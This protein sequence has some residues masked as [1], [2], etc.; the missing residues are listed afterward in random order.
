M[1]GN[2]ESEPSPT[3]FVFPETDIEAPATPANLRWEEWPGTGDDKT[4]GMTLRLMWDSSPGATSYSIVKNDVLV[5]S[6]VTSTSWTDTDVEYLGRYA[7]DVYAFSSPRIRTPY[8]AYE[9]GTLITPSFGTAHPLPDDLT[10]MHS[11]GD[12]YRLSWTPPEDARIRAWMTY[13]V[14][15][16]PEPLTDLEGSVPISSSHFFDR[17]ENPAYEKYYYML[18][19]RLGPYVTYAQPSQVIRFDMDPI[20]I[21]PA[22]IGAFL[23]DL[24]EP[25]ATSDHRGSLDDRVTSRAYRFTLTQAKTVTLKV[26][27]IRYSDSDLLLLDDELNELETSQ[28]KNK[29][30]E[31]IT[32]ALDPGTYYA[33]VDNTTAD[34]TNNYLFTIEVSP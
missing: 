10:L 24:G 13:N 29:A 31:T 23:V 14:R 12:L 6:R 26:T 17:L 32:R 33:Y 16:F 30:D 34:G 22:D 2:T 1:S 11:G 5:A 25:P 8:S 27:N 21:G 3:I 9:V 28:N 18:R 15:R 19:I 4:D 7:Y 20:F